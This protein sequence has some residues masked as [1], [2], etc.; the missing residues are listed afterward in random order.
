M[1]SKEELKKIAIE[2]LDKIFL[3]G[4]ALSRLDIEEQLEFLEK[5]SNIEPIL[6]NNEQQALDSTNK[7]EGSSNKVE[8]ITNGTDKSDRNEIYEILSGYIRTSKSEFTPRKIRVIYYRMLLANNIINSRG[9]GLPFSSDIYKEIFDQ[10]SGCE[11]K[12]NSEHAFFN[13]VEMVVPY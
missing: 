3:T 2:Q 10:S 1:F 12:L 11:S 13:V 4:I 6:D 8:I 5:I 9:N 7:H